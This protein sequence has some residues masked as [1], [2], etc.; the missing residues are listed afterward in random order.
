M[1]TTA[2]GEGNRLSEY[3]PCPTGRS[4]YCSRDHDEK[5]IRRAENL[6]LV[7]L[8]RLYPSPCFCSPMLPD[9]HSIN[10]TVPDILGSGM[11]PRLPPALDDIV[12]LFELDRSNSSDGIHWKKLQ[13]PQSTLALECKQDIHE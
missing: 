11:N 4:T 9:A 7:S 8:E 12:N 3:K 10:P 13:L 6:S 2:N 5:N 1:H